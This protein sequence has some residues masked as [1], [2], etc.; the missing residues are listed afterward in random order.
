MK[1]ETTH[2][3]YELQPY[4]PAWKKQFIAIAETIRPVFGDNVISIEHVGSTAIACSDMVAKPNI[5]VCVVVKD[6]NLIPSVYHDFTQLGY[7]PLGREYVGD[8]D[9]YV[10]KDDPVTG[11]RLESIHIYQEG[12]PKPQVY[13]EFRDYLISHQEDR[14]RYVALKKDLFSHHKDAYK[15]YD[16]G[17]ADL[18]VEIKQKAS[19]WAEDTSRGLAL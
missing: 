15:R 16:N 2:R 9:E 6:L 14:Q 11:Q 13:R 5:D 12:H 19:Q 17:K 1:K 8:G 3:P 18:I 7:T 10:V 4:N